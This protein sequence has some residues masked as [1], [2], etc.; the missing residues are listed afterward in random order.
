[1]TTFTDRKGTHVFREPTQ[2][3]GWRS[4][5][6]CWHQKAYRDLPVDYVREETPGRPRNQP[7]WTVI[8]TIMGEPNPKFKAAAATVK[9]AA[10]ASAK[11]IA[12]SGHCVGELRC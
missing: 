7:E 3:N 11:L 10:E 2:T 5:V 9:E 4:L 1:M 6:N 8:P 12:E